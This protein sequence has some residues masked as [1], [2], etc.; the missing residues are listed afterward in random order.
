MEK[1]K[2]EGWLLWTVFEADVGEDGDCTEAASGL[3]FRVLLFQYLNVTMPIY[4]LK[5]HPLC[6]VFHLLLL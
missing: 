4:F 1:A 2:R 5:T 6:R 3:D